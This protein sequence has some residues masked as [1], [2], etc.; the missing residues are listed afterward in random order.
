MKTSR[1]PYLFVLALGLGGFGLAGAAQDKTEAPS[2]HGIV[3]SEDLQWTPIIAGWELAV[4]SGD[5]DKEGE[6]FVIRLRGKDGAKVPAHWHPTDESVTVLRGTFLVGMGDG[7][8][9]AKLQAMAAGSFATVPKEMRHFA[10]AKGETS[11]QV[12]GVGPFKVNWVNPADVVPPP[13]K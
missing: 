9:E 2:K 11:V 7:Y 5:I 10:K 4:V 12:H 3:R 8:D 13:K 6:P 1:K